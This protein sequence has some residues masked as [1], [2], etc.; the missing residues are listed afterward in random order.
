MGKTKQINLKNWTYYFYNHI[1]NIDESDGSKI[2]VDKKNFNGIDIYYLDYEYK[3][4]NY[5]M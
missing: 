3:K 5:R 4:K 2:K 1:I